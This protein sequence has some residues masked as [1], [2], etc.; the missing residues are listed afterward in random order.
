MATC[1]PVCKEMLGPHLLDLQN[2][3]TPGMYSL[4]W[5]SMNID[6]YLNRVHDRLGKVEE[7]IQ[8]SND[9][10]ENRVEANLKAV[11]KTMLLNLPKDRSF[12]YEE[13]V[14]TQTKFINAQTKGVEVRNVEI[15]RGVL[16]L[17]ELVR[18]TPRENQLDE[19]LPQSVVDAFT[20]HYARFMYQSILTCT[21]TSFLA[22]RTRLG[23]RSSG[24]FLYIERPIFGVDV[25]LQIP[26][27][28]MNPSLD[29]IQDAINVVAKKMLKASEKLH[30]WGLG[31]EDTTGGGNSPS[32]AANTAPP[33]NGNYPSNF[34]HWI[35][36]DKEIVKSVLLLTG[37]IEGT[38][39]RVA[40]FPNPVD[41]GGPIPG[42]F[43]LI[44]TS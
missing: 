26:R 43:L 14:A 39:V 8:K 22:M 19:V 40:R 1:A 12:T 34:Y 17:C 27:V 16:D 41:C 33:N 44:H 32:K 5:T 6:G 42:D 31:T 29:D 4:T 38:K 13:F 28:T 23:S 21:R 3:L 18:T 25:E 36:S 15:E 2:A 10:L 37:S 7:L 11:A 35:A 24:G 9:I 20:K 30:M